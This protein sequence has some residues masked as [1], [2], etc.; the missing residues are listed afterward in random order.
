[1]DYGGVDHYTADQG[2]VWLF[3]GRSKSVGAGSAYGSVCDTKAPLQLR[4]AACGAIQVLYAF[5]FALL[6]LVI[7]NF[8]LFSHAF[9]NLP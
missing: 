8:R 2:C 4:Y 5:A 1:M 3:G 7:V 9:Y 6:S